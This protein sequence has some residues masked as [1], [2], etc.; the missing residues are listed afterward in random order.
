MSFITRHRRVSWQFSQNIVNIL[1]ESQFANIEDSIRELIQNAADAGATKVHIRFDESDGV[2]RVSDDGSGMSYDE[3]IERFAKIGESFKADINGLR[4]RYGMGRFG[5]IGI[6]DRV[7]WITSN[8][9]TGAHIIVD[10][11]TAQEGFYIRKIRDKKRGTIVKAKIR[12]E[13]LN[14]MDGKIRNLIETKIMLPWIKITY[15]NKPMSQVKTDHLAIYKTEIENVSARIYLLG[16]KART[17]SNGISVF[18]YGLHG[19]SVSYF[20]ALPALV[21]FQG[22]VFPISRSSCKVSD[23]AIMRAVTSC[24]LNFLD[25]KYRD[26]YVIKK[27]SDE[28]IRDRFITAFN[29]GVKE[30]GKYVVIGGKTLRQWLE[31]E[32]E[33]LWASP[34]Q[35][36]LIKD[37]ESLGIK[38]LKV[39]F[40]D[41][42]VPILR[43]YGVKNVLEDERL[44]RKVQ[45]AEADENLVK[46]VKEFFDKCGKAIEKAL[47]E[48]VRSL[49]EKKEVSLVVRT[50]A[51]KSPETQ[52]SL[53]ALVEYLKSNINRIN[54]DHGE[55]LL[56]PS[57]I[58]PLYRI[59]QYN[60]FFG[61]SLSEELDRGTLAW[62][63]GNS[64]ILNI[65]NKDVREAILS[66]N[67]PVLIY[68][69]THEITHALGYRWHDTYFVEA[70]TTLFMKVM[71]ELHKGGETT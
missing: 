40:T 45:L 8:G 46:N 21:D 7:E 69:I 11:E 70:H 61:E 66:Q 2:L 29:D 41:R 58:R 31:D 64:I 65:S 36:D 19:S 4:G 32:K 56:N 60:V 1:M 25:E 26:P 6:S 22:K 63:L 9:E 18:E 49:A 16:P 30:I 51:V 14:E 67:Y 35:K 38:V 3:A 28:K 27:I 68:I 47:N 24:W 71:K 17:P 55:S 57:T 5:I 33:L 23:L 62:R 20:G 15:N 10:R 44:R 13:Y 34:E 12:H 42:V 37:A 39:P 43:E 52:R 59:G 54:R 53:E 50:T 48:T